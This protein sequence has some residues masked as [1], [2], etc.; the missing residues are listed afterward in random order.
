MGEGI[1]WGAWA[2]PGEA[3]RGGQGASRPAARN[4]GPG[5]AFPPG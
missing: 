1:P 3:T 4:P 5:G 2:G